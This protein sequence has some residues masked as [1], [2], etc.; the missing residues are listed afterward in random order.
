[1]TITSHLERLSRANLVIALCGAGLVSLAWIGGLFEGSYGDVLFNVHYV[2]NDLI[3]AVAVAL[4]IVGW[5][6]WRELPLLVG[7]LAVGFWFLGS[8]YWT[9]YVWFAGKV[10]VYPSLD[11]F[12]YES[13]H[14]LMLVLAWYFLGSTETRFRHPLVLVPIVSAAL[15]TIVYLSLGHFSI[16]ALAFNTVQLGMSGAL[17]VIGGHLL[18]TRYRLFGVALITFAVADLSFLL[19]TL[20]DSTPFIV[21]LDPLWFTSHALTSFALLRY[22]ANG[23]LP[24]SNRGES[25]RNDLE[26]NVS[27]VGSVAATVAQD[28][29][30]SP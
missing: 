25:S 3:I 12:A 26:E 20:V 8:L 29:G 1:M 19:I 23:Q 21:F 30:Q 27:R 28:G 9:S 22:A 14:L 7:A 16:G 2:F 15:P 24:S 5:R 4:L 17:G 13:F 18:A 6:H 11:K 10:L